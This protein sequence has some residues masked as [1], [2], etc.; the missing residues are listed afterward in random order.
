M[1]R[2]P[3]RPPAGRPPSPAPPT[4]RSLPEW[5]GTA[6]P[7]LGSSDTSPATP[8]AQ[9]AWHDSSPPPRSTPSN[10]ATHPT[11]TAP[12]SP[13]TSVPRST[14]VQ[15]EVLDSPRYRLTT[16]STYPETDLVLASTPPPPSLPLIQR[17]AHD[18]PNHT[19]WRAGSHVR[20]SA[21]SPTAAGAEA[22]RVFRPPMQLAKHSTAH[23][24]AR[25]RSA[26]SNLP[27]AVALELLR[28][29]AERLPYVSQALRECGHIV[30]GQRDRECVHRGVELIPESFAK[31]TVSP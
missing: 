12:P 5:R 4:P 22:V 27:C 1:V 2:P 8:P 17:S 6:T 29:D 13:A 7:P 14:P 28:N 31:R 26:I 30:P 25:S 3:G 16:T 20:Q 11:D 19:T 10:T 21:R 24:R 18:Y 23:L 9:A 15:D